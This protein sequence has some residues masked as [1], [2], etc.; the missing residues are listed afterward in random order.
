[1]NDD[2]MNSQNVNSKDTTNKKEELKD[3]DNENKEGKKDKIEIDEDY[4]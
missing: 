1:M 2:E 3:I 4:K